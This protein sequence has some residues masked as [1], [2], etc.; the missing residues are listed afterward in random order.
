MTSRAYWSIAIPTGGQALKKCAGLLG[1]LGRNAQTRKLLFVLVCFFYLGG[2][3]F[4]QFFDL[5]LH[6]F[7]LGL[8]KSDVLPQSGGALD[9]SK[10]ANDGAQDADHG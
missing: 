9:V 7:K 10:T 5:L 4:L 6:E 3:V 8:V 2:K 1:V